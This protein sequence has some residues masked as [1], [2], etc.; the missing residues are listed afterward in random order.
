MNIS[1]I[2]FYNI[3]SYYRPKLK[4]KANSVAVTYITL[5]QVSLLLLLGI[6]FAGFFRQ[7]NMDT[8]SSSKAWTLF[9]LVAVFIYFKN[10]IQY[11]GKRRMMINAKMNKRNITNTYNIYLLWLL[12]FVVLGLT[13]VVFQ[14][15]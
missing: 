5:L 7:M 8:M 1:D 15:S 6:F 13:Y 12:P 2:L 3:F 4:Q 14:A 11:T 10:W 9:T